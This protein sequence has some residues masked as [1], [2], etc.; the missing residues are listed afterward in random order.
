MTNRELEMG[1]GPSFA[2]FKYL[3]YP[4]QRSEYPIIDMLVWRLDDK[5]AKRKEK[6]LI[7]DYSSLASEV[8]SRGEAHRG[9][10]KNDQP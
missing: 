7:R 10:S 9:F 3:C 1:G 6:K 4:K 5:S 2:V 8:G